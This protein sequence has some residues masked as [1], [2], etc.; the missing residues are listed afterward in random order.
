MAVRQGKSITFSDDVPLQREIVTAS[1]MRNLLKNFSEALARSSPERLVL[2]RER[3][4]NR[5]LYNGYGPEIA[6][7]YMLSILNMLMDSFEKHSGMTPLTIRHLGK[8]LINRLDTAHTLPELVA[9]FRGVVDALLRYQK[10]PHEASVASRLNSIIEEIHRDPSYAW[11]LSKLSKQA[12]L[13]NPT[14]LKWF[15]KIT[16]LSFGSYVRQV[17]LAKA[18]DLLRE[19]RLTLEHIAQECGFSSSSSFIQIFRRAQGVTP[20]QFRSKK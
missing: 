6:R 5:I 19:G 1:D 3:F 4:I 8:E 11:R 2:A 17:R 9:S 16:G 10:K 13:S 18:K 14:F 15:Q 12:D 7:A 20:G